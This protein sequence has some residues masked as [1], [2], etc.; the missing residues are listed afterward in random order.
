MANDTCSLMYVWLCCIYPSYSI[1]HIFSHFMH[2]I[3]SIT[4][5]TEKKTIAC[6]IQDNTGGKYL[7]GRPTCGLHGVCP[8]PYISCME[9]PNI[10]HQACASRGLCEAFLTW[11]HT[12]WQYTILVRSW[13]FMCVRWYYEAKSMCHFMLAYV[14]ILSQV[15]HHYMHVLIAQ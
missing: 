8:Y 9:T 4:L 14:Y 13:I 3:A 15:P 6:L 1:Q 10:Y 7:S 12:C 5:S 11:A 2:W